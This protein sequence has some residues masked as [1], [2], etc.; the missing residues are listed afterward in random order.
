M[1]IKAKSFSGK[2]EV[3]LKECLPFVTTKY[4]LKMNSGDKLL[5]AEEPKEKE[6]FIYD[7]FLARYCDS[8][9]FHNGDPDFYK[10]SS[11]SFISGSIIPTEIYK[12][13]IQLYYQ[14]ILPNPYKRNKFPKFGMF[15]GDWILNSDYSFY[16]SETPSYDFTYLMW[17]G[18]MEAFKIF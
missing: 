1:I 18:K 4:I 3:C 6:G 11:S 15:A 12:K 9:F 2:Y 8:R 5:F 13:L 17:G 14:N 16:I 7:I 10:R